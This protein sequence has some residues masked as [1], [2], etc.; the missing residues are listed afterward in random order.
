MKQSEQDNNIMTIDELQLMTPQQLLE[1]SKQGQLVVGC[2]FTELEQAK[3]DKLA[4][5]IDIHD[6][7]GLLS[8]GSSAQDKLTEFSNG[9]LSQ[10]DTAKLGETGK[11]LV[12]V[13]TDLKTYN[14]NLEN[15]KNPIV[16]FFM[17]WK[18]RT[19]E[20]VVAAKAS[21]QSVCDN[22]DAVDKLLVEEHYKPLTSEIRSFRE[23]S[24]LLNDTYRELSMYIAAGQQRLNHAK[25]VELPALDKKAQETK[26]NL[27]IQMLQNVAQDINDFESNLLCLETSREQ[28]MFQMAFVRKLEDIYLE[29]ARQIQ[30]LRRNT[31]PTWRN[32]MRLNL[33]MQDALDAQHS[34]KVIRQFANDVHVRA[35]EQLR[36]LNAQTAEHMNKPVISIETSIKVNEV[37]K[38]MLNDDINI[39]NKNMQEVHEGREILK[40]ISESRDEMLRNYAVNVAKI[41][42]Q[43]AYQ[44]SD[45]HSTRNQ[46]VYYKVEEARASESLLSNSSQATPDDEPKKYT[47]D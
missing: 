15:E 19:E 28:C 37:L 39:L 44:E 30:D 16:K 12:Q 2:T 21:F 24:A 26:S 33:G 10:Y 36:E 3:V 18:Q 8:Y 7:L 27:D 34:I 35:A 42:V 41:A 14:P 20:T 6:R 46:E 47:L 5:K 9:R 4:N 29:T 13:V 31:I 11:A 1:K 22:I 45:P 23:M 43:H 32:Q 38:G 40:Q 17:G 25:K